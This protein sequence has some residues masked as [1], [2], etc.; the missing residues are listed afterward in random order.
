MMMKIRSFF[1][2]PSLAYGQ[3]GRK[4]LSLITGGT[5][6]EPGGTTGGTGGG[7]SETEEAPPMWYEPDDQD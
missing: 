7:S 1:N 6:G 3:L 5:G 2:T 4:S